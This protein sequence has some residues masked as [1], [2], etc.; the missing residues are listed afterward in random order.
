M[1]PII[2]IPSS[3]ALNMFLFCNENIF[4]ST[5]KSICS[6]IDHERF[7]NNLSNYIGNKNFNWKTNQTSISEYFLFI[8]GENNIYH[9]VFYSIYFL[10]LFYYTYFI[11]FKY[12]HIV[13][14]E[15]KDVKLINKYNIFLVTHNFL[16][17]NYNTK[18]I[19][20]LIFCFFPLMDFFTSFNQYKFLYFP[21]LYFKYL[22]ISFFY[23]S[24]MV[25]GYMIKKKYD[26][27]Q[28]DLIFS[29]IEETTPNKNIIEKEESLNLEFKSSFQ[30]PYPNAPKEFRDKNN[31]IYYSIG[32]HKRYKS[33][34]EIE[35]LLQNMALEAIVGF[36]N[37]SGGKLVIGISEKDNLKKVVGIEF[38]G[39]SSSDSYER[40]I[41]Q[42]I[43]NRIG[44]VYMGEYIQTE[45]IQEN[46]KN[47]FII[48]IKPFY[49][50][51]GQIPVLLDG[52]DCFIRTGPRT[53]KIEAGANF[54]EFISQRIFQD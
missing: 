11:T 43:I 10:C 28:S 31:Q 5:S 42:I 47:L 16:K 18:K 6:S 21:L 9:R 22:A 33:L 14:D 35:K 36:L 20:V 45:I 4:I 7:F 27:Y 12:N 51:P 15:K 8:T 3:A 34:K 50:K 17:N 1:F 23:F 30:T 46:G 39:F 49:P 2:F 24:P 53:D 25:I 19:L 29:M 41:I 40:H 44:L 13:G 38:E 37:S 32:G 54:A 26:K 52:K 48:N